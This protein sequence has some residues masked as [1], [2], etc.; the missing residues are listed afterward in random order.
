MSNYTSHYDCRWDLFRLR[1]HMLHR[2]LIGCT[3]VLFQQLSGQNSLL[4]YAPTLFKL[5]GFSS[6]IAATLATVGV[7]LVKFL[8]SIFNLYSLDKFGRRPLLLI[9]ISILAFSMLLLGSLSIAF[10]DP[11]L[12][13]S[14][15]QARECNNYTIVSQSEYTF[16]ANTTLTSSLT[17]TKWMSLILLMAYVGA[18][19]ISFGSISWLL[20]T[21]LFPPSVRGQAVSLSTTVNWSMNL[22]IS[23]T[24]LSIYHALLGYTYIIY[25][26]FCVLGLVCLFV[27]VPETKGK[28]LEKISDELKYRKL[29]TFIH[30]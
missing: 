22:I 24:L 28:S 4:Y 11:H 14:T 30:K 16:P 6:G 10:V 19:E 18:Y 20:L 15:S 13:L 5:L 2:L 7:G 29:F 26:L 1:D 23:V 8:C 17:A 3:V 12:L 9:G 27:M 25:G 21:E